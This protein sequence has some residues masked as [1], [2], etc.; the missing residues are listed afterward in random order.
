MYDAG[1]SAG[2]HYP[3][4]LQLLTCVQIQMQSKAKAKYKGSIDCARQ[5]FREGGIRSIYR[6]TAATL[7]RGLIGS[8]SVSL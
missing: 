6:G 5:L 2:Y 8:I 1:M 4:L 7:L 3:R